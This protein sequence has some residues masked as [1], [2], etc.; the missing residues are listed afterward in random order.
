MNVIFALLVTLSQVVGVGAV[1]LMGVYLGNYAGGFGWGYMNPHK[2]NYHPLF[3]TIGL[4]F[5]YGDGEFFLK[6]CHH[7]SLVHIPPFVNTPRVH[8]PSDQTLTAMCN[9]YSN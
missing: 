7:L 1:I 8:R 2:F 5:L 3:M 4:I 9:Q 6:R